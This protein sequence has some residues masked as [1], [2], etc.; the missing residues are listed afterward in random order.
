ML[1]LV[2]N[3]D[4]ECVLTPNS[5]AT[6]VVVIPELGSIVTSFLCYLTCY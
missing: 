6:S 4:T 2:H 1:E 5:F 3:Y